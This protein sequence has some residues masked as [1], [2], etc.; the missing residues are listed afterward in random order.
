MA[1]RSANIFKNWSETVGGGDPGFH[2]IGYLVLVDEKRA[3]GLHRNVERARGTGAAVELM[4]RQQI[5]EMV[6]E[7]ELNDVVMASFEAESGYADPHSTTLAL[8]ERAQELGAEILQY[9]RV[10]RILT[11]G[12]RVVGVA[13]SAGS[14]SAPAVVICAGPWSD[15][16]LRPVGVEINL[17]VWRHQMCLFA[18]PPQF[19]RH[20]VIRDIPNQTYMRPDLGNLTIHGLGHSE[21]EVDPDNY[22]GTVDPDQVIRNIELITHRFPVMVDAVSRGGYAGIYDFTAD[23]QPILG[24]I[25]AATGLYACFGWSGHGFKNAPASGEALADIILL[26]HSETCDLT[27]FRWS[28]FREGDAF[29]TDH[30]PAAEVR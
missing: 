10:E 1:S 22:D 5:K 28:R 19:S 23:G 11:A 29:P 17:R 16:L 2:E 13:T 21:E 18:R 7:I 14:I 27:P 26:G 24:P 20:P 12:G 15:R 30:S 25:D 3:D 4:D 8:A 6:P 9:T